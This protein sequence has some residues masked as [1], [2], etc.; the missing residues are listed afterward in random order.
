MT[1]V[2]HVTSPTATLWRENDGAVF[3]V[4]SRIP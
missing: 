3:T 2:A 4:A 1:C